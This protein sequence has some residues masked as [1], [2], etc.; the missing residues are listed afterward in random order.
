MVVNVILIAMSIAL[1][2]I[3]SIAWGLVGLNVF[4]KLGLKDPE[5]P[6]QYILAAIIF[7]PI[8]VIWLIGELFFNW[9][10]KFYNS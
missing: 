6:K 2:S 5:N 3:A 1:I 9:L 7:G 4:E 8:A 10:K